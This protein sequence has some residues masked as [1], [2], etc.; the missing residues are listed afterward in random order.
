M[1][2]IPSPR[3]TQADLDLWATEARADAIHGALQR[4]DGLEARA[5]AS[6][7]IFASEATFYAGVSWGKDSLV[8][9]HLVYRVGLP[10]PVLW[11]PAGVVENPDSA[12][13]RDAFLKRFDIDY[14][15]R[16]C[17][18]LEWSTSGTEI[19]HDGAQKDFERAT[20]ACGARYASG[21]RGDESGVRALRMKHFGERSKNTCAPLGFWKWHDVYAYAAKYDLPLH[22]AYACL[23][24]GLY[25]RD[26]I[27]V[28]T[29]GGVNGGAGGRREWEQQYYPETVRLVRGLG[30]AWAAEQMRRA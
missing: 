4:L 14:K 9:A 24:G 26:R 18:T 17:I 12:I 5:L 19:V 2:L 30:R 11:F 16:P 27:R 15:E 1:A 29:I 10:I 3:H 21:I 7:R 13:V 20:K 22:P 23:G 6:L 28:A 8:L 25:A